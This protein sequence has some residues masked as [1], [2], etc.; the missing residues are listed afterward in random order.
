MKALAWLVAVCLRVAVRRWPEVQR[1]ERMREWSAELYVMGTWSRL[2]FAWSLAWSPPVDDD[3]VPRGWRETL[4]AFGRGLR[5]V[6]ALIGAGLVC[7]GLANGVPASG[8]WILTVLRGYPSG[9]GPFWPNGGI[10]WAA[11]AVSASALALAAVSAFWIGRWVGARTPVTWAHRG[12]LGS[13]GSAMIAPVSI[14]VGVLLV[15][16]LQNARFHDEFGTR[17]YVPATEVAILV[18][19]VLTTVVVVSVVRQVNAG[20]R[21]RAWLTALLGGLV[22]LDI[23][24]IVAT[25]RPASELK[26]QAASA[27]L[28]FPLTLLDL[29]G[30]G[31]RF[32]YINQGLIGSEVIA[33]NAA[34]VTRPMLIAVGFL[35]G[36]G[37]AAS[38]TVAREAAVRLPA[39][40]Q[41]KA[42][43]PLPR[44]AMAIPA[45]ALALWAYG[46]TGI[47]G[48]LNPVTDQVGE[49]HIWAHEIRQAAI[50]AA[51]AGLAL[52]LAGRGPVVFPAALAF[53]A[54]AAADSVFDTI[55]AVN[56]QSGVLAFALGAGVLYGAWGL[57]RALRNIPPQDAV[58]RSLA[59]F[60]VLAAA[61][62]P[63]VA[64]HVP[65]FGTLLPGSFWIA[66]GIAVALLTIVAQILALMSRE[67]PIR[68]VVA[69]PLVLA[70]GGIAGYA[71]T[72]HPL[73]AFAAAPLTV[74]TI[75]LMRPAKSVWKRA[76]V[77]LA[78]LVAAI[79]LGYAQLYASL[80]FG[81]ILM[82]AAGYSFPVDGLPFLPGSILVGILLS[83]VVSTK[84]VP[85]PA[86][87]PPHAA[88][89]VQPE[90]VR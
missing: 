33:R 28:W 50:V 19:V 45:L 6:L 54:L 59:G 22:A 11:N 70:L 77:M 38:Q 47:T 44:L 16:A 86:S 42:F 52:L 30:S 8:S 43:R 64:F 56:V 12:W 67:H 13:A 48:A 73:F 29:E 32:G 23:T 82:V 79:P 10:D 90:P 15:Y 63:A 68:T 51:V 1:E 62:A 2:R 18:W 65:D 35:A 20:H 36:Y 40:A 88:P 14:A 75:W 71:S 69:V 41:A 3:G 34:L 4:P 81:E 87:P 89:A 25:F 74:A 37:I 21:V 61:C 80:M 53:V 31:V 83:V 57:S 9:S 27:P 78:A 55:D 49:H 60:A 46:L 72:L 76:A 58:R 66:S 17:I 5:P 85:R 39:L 26:I 24:A 7:L 84:V